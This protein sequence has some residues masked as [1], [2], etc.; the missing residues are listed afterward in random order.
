MALNILPGTQGD[1]TNE[2][3]QNSLNYPLPK[4]AIPIKLS[5]NTD[6]SWVYCNF[7]E[8]I[9]DN[10]M[11][12][13]KSNVS[14][15]RQVVK[16]GN[17][18]I[19]YSHYNQLSANLHY[20]IRIYNPNSTS[21]TITPT[22]YG[23]SDSEPGWSNA[24]GCSWENF[25]KG[26]NGCLITSKT[27]LKPN[28][29]LWIMDKS[30]KLGV[31]SGNLRFSTTKSVAVSVYAYFDRSKVGNATTIFSYDNAFSEVKNEEE[32]KKMK[33]VYS[34]LGEGFFFTAKQITLKASEILE[35]G[36]IYFST[37]CRNYTPSY[38]MEVNKVEKSELIPIHIAGTDKI[39]AVGKSSPLHNVGN[40][41]AQYYIPI[42]LENDLNYPITFSGYV[43]TGVKKDNEIASIFIISSGSNTKYGKVSSQK[44]NSWNWLNCTIPANDSIDDAYQFIFG[45]NSTT[46]VNH[47]FTVKA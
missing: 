21:V 27:E 14:L 22:N 35:K 38:L 7:P 32:R 26:P 36:G 25:F 12:A 43:Q 3:R 16:A 19:F 31:F 4:T 39:A 10:T 42:R 20:G 15:N 1:G 5:I 13:D 44:F 47:I 23:H 30:I 6:S 45:T 18:Q 2:R 46:P 40:W 17:V 9:T 24:S 37:H 33:M 34:G 28:E 29:S 11:L 41:C 8:N